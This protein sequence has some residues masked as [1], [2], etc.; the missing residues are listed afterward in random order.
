MLALTGCQLLSTS[1]FVEDDVVLLLALSKFIIKINL[2]PDILAH[3][4][5][6][7]Y[8][9]GRGRRISNSRPAHPGK[10]RNPMTK[11]KYKAKGL[12][13]GSGIEFLPSMH[14]SLSAILTTEKKICFLTWDKVIHKQMLD[15]LPLNYS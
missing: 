9:E 3:T 5:N 7:D 14:E 11:A 6:P 15:I 12:G 8:L 13:C 4:Y 10:V 1:L 2:K